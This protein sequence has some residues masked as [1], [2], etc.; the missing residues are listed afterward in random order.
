MTDS[1]DA[2]GPC[3]VGVG[4]T[5]TR[6]RFT[7]WLVKAGVVASV[8]VGRLVGFAPTAWAAPD[9]FN[10]PDPCPGSCTISCIGYC[11]PYNSC[12]SVG[13]STG[14]VCCGCSQKGGCDFNARVVGQ[15][16]PST[17]YYCCSLCS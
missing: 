17:C 9:C 15:C 7:G 2:A 8:G 1:H 3:G 13:G 6:R 14:T 4:A 16:T 10:T 11:D 5:I 12:C